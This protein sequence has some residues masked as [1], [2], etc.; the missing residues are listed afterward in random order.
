MAADE[1]M[2]I[3]MDIVVDVEPDIDEDI[4]RMQAEINEIHTVRRAAPHTCPC[5]G[6]SGILVD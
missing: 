2:D 6:H 5:K 1:S 3:D 4:A